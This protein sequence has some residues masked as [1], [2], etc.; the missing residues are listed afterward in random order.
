MTAD[1]T[2]AASTTNAMIMMSRS[3]ATAATDD[4]IDVGCRGGFVPSRVGI[5]GCHGT[6]TI[7]MMWHVALLAVACCCGIDSRFIDSETK[8]L[9][10]TMTAEN[11]RIHSSVL[12]GTDASFFHSTQ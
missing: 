11:G 7:S 4:N 8:T 2:A 5:G 3:N 6:G 12:A 9:D 10:L 1:A